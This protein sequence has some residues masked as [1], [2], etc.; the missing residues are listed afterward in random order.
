MDPITVDLEAWPLEDL[1]SALTR[2]MELEQEDAR[3]MAEA[4]CQLFQGTFSMED[5]GLEKPDRALLWELMV[6]GVVTM[7]SETR[8]H[9]EHGRP[10]RYYTWHLVPPERL[11]AGPPPEPAV[12]PE[13]ELGEAGLVYQELPAIAWRSTRA[14]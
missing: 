14:V 3:E 5:N 2:R 7:D 12:E 1:A 6:N 9:P 8:P 4:I 11:L 13:P 10:W